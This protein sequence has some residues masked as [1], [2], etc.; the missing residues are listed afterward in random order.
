MDDAADPTAELLEALKDDS[1]WFVRRNVPVFK[2]HERTVRDPK[3]GK[4]RVVK[5][6]RKE[7]EEI[8]ATYRRLMAEVGVPPRI[9]FGHTLD[10]APEERQPPPKGWCQHMRVGTFG[11]GNVEA[12]LI[13]EYIYPAHA[14]EAKSYPYRSPEYYESRK[15]ISGVA[16]LRRDPQLDLGIVYS[17]QSDSTLSYE[18]AGRPWLYQREIQMPGEMPNEDPAK[19]VP[20]ATTP[21]DADFEKFSRMI[22]RHPVL[23]YVCSKYEREAQQPPMPPAPAPAPGSPPA[24]EGPPQRMSRAEAERQAKYERELAESRDRIAALELR[25]RMNRYQRALEQDVAPFV[26]ID[27][28]AE[29]AYV[30]KHKMDDAAFGEHKD[31]LLKYNRH[32]APVG[33]PMLQTERPGKKEFT[34][35]HLEKAQRYM[36]DEYAR[37]GKN[38]TWAE[39]KEYALKN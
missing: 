18:M 1:R 12:V 6:G 30:T 13:D 19:A 36:R 22:D 16:L 15:E 39:A 24:P 4:T 23:R 8:C 31:R 10:D 2:A 29:M 32:A 17:R 9:T 21:E 28:A 38:P 27:L 33:G 34:E 7:L 5:V 35:E 25:D 3:T 37:T 11:P 26:E 20:G 14:A